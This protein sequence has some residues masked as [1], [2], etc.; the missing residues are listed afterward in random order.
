M[1]PNG[2]YHVYNRGIN[3]C[4]IF[5]KEENYA[6]FLKKYE[7]YIQPIAQTYA[8]CLLGNHFHFLI[9]TRSNEE[10]DA[11][12][13]TN[14]GKGLNTV[15]ISRTPSEIIS[16]QFSHLFNAYAQAFNKA[17]QR[18]GGLFET[19]FRRK[20]ITNN[21]Y[22][23]NMVGYIHQ[24][25]QKHGF[26]SDFRDYPHSSYHSFISA[27]KTA[28]PRKTVLEWFGGNDNYVAFHANNIITSEGQDWDIEVED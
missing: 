4:R 27:K 17:T 11:I 22:F 10:I 12:Y 5:A 8:Y 1:Y 19:P 20:P 26:V 13:P 21:D 24:N 3:G 28:L 16:R 15:G 25:P 23:T 2:Y 9:G 7:Q 14:V 18:T 6:H